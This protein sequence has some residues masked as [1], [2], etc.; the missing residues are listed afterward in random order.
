MCG[1]TLKRTSLWAI[2]ALIFGA[3]QAFAA[4]CFDLEFED[5]SF[6]ACRADPATE[7]IRL[8]LNDGDGDLL[9]TFSAVEGA[10]ADEGLAL[11]FATNGGMYHPDR[12]PVGHYVEEGQELRRVITSSGPGNF[13]L[14]PNGVLCLSEGTATLT[15]SRRYADV[16]PTC[17]FATQ[18]GPMLV[19]DGALHPRF[20]ADGTSRFI[21]NGVG[22]DETGDLI[23]AISNAPVNFHRFARMFRDVLKT[24]NA[25][26]LDGNISRLHAPDLGRSDAGFPMGPILGVT[27]PQD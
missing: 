9:G 24:P 4:E 1:G 23:V 15:E 3:S 14:L 18:S 27:R 8:W 19:I 22:I 2:A 13:G 10:L 7:D 5:T 11:A 12:S 17:E 26:Y 6:T 21:R 16:M 25:L 20:L